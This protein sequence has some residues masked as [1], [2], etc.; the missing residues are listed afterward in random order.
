MKTIIQWNSALSTE[1]AR[2]DQQHKELI[3]LVNKMHAC[4]LEPD[5]THQFTEQLHLLH[6]N[7]LQ[8][9]AEEEKVMSDI[10]YPHLARHAAEP[11]QLLH[12]ARTLLAEIRHGDVKLNP[13]ITESLRE[14]LLDHI[15]GEHREQGLFIQKHQRHP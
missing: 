3:S 8:H 5:A 11:R 10:G 14:W 15:L 6:R 9:F 12:Q 2:L 1:H 13:Q 4:I 7:T